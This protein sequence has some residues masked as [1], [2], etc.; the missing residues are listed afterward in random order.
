MADL[1][2]PVQPLRLAGNGLRNRSAPASALAGD[3]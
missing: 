1:G 3:Q 2:E